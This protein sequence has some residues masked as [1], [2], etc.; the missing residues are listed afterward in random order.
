MIGLVVVCFFILAISLSVWFAT[1]GTTAITYKVHEGTYL[2][3]FYSADLKLY[4][5]D[6]SFSGKT[7]TSDGT[8]SF[9]AKY[10]K[11][12]N[13]KWA[14][15]QSG[16]GNDRGYEVSTDRSG[17]VYL[18]G[19]YGSGVL[20]LYN[21]DNTLHPTPLISEGNNSESFLAKYDKD[22][23]VKWAARQSGDGN[24]YGRG[25]STDRF[26]N[27]YL[28]GYYDAALNLYN[29]DNTTTHAPLTSDNS[30][31]FLAK[32]DK[33]GTVEW[34]AR[35]A[36]GRDDHG[37][38]VST[39]RS[40]NVYLTGHYGGNGGDLKLYNHD[41]TTTHPPLTSE[42]ADYDS[43]LAKYDK[44]GTVVWAAQQS[45]DG[46]DRG[47]GISA[48]R[49]GNVYLTGNYGGGNDGVLNLYNHDNTTTR[50]PLTSEGN[51]DSFLAKYD[52]NGT[53]EWAAQQSGDGN[54]R[55]YGISADRS[56]N[57]Y[58]T[59]YYGSGVLN[60]YNHDNTL[61]PTPLTIEGNFDSF[62]AKYDKNGNV[63]WA[64]RQSGGETDFGH[65]VSTDRSGNVYLTGYYGSVG[66]LE[67][68][69]QG[70]NVAHTPTLTNEGN[71]NNSFLAK[72]DK[73][74]NVEWAAR[75]AGDGDGDD[76]G[77]GV[78]TYYE[79]EAIY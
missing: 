47:Y 48:D 20:N 12:G 72:Y 43:F 23:N 4:N 7:L 3:G 58:L 63:E 13:V 26:G 9:L 31:S 17:N 45:G 51:F 79:L 36:G 64:A 37:Y 57:V 34:A 59:G 6:G 8:S 71:Y 53:V 5:Q 40:G 33:D 22:G 27:V 14:A 25:V 19:Y 24:D 39:D 16:D 15:R 69:D 21:H 46:N 10:D 30:D 49:S 60:L 18:T 62:L 55:G 56:G 54:D 66:D 61:H 1:T 29:H 73:N 11:D 38:G 35:Q 67:L 32:Y 70:S 65:G 52:K 2:T 44:D 41:N 74:G 78:S 42:G 50:A 77:Y 68:Y 28:T 76:L 75:Q